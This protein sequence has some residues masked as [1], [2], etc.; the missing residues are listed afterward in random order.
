LK[1]K[2]RGLPRYGSTGRGDLH[3]RIIVKVPSNLTDRQKALLKE[4]H[5]ELDNNQ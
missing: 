3:V 2:G 1:V 4:L 5:K